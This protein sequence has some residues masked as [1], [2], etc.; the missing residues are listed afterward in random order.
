[1]MRDRSSSLSVT[2]AILLKAELHLN[3]PKTSLPSQ[4]D[5]SDFKDPT[6]PTD[7]SRGVEPA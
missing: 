2:R 4:S 1:M 6:F 3:L 5:F 7:L